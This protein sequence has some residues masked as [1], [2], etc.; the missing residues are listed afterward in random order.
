MARILVIDDEK[1]IRVTLS[2]ML[3]D[4]GHDVQ[5]VEDS[6]AALEQLARQNYDVVISDM[7]LP[8]LSGSALVERLREV[9]PGVP[10]I[11]M[12]G[13][14]SVDTAS[15]AVRAR[16][17]DYLLKPIRRDR[18]LA[19]V[20]AAADEK[21][22]REELERLRQE[23]RRYQDQLE[24]L[25]EQQSMNATEQRALLALIVLHAPLAVAVYDQD[26][27]YLFVSQ[28][29]LEDF[30]VSGSHLVGKHLYE[31]FPHIELARR[32]LHQRVLTGALHERAEDDYVR[33]DGLTIHSRW[34]FRPWT[35]GDG[36]IGGMITYSEGR[37][38]VG[39]VAGQG[40]SEVQKGE[41]NGRHTLPVTTHA[42]AVHELVLDEA[43]K[44]VDL[45]RH[46]EELHA[47]NEALERFTRA[48]T[49]RELRMIELKQEVNGLARLL[50]R[51]QPYP[52]D[53]LPA[54]QRSHDPGKRGSS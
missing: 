31:V 5:T 41:Q 44:P 29:Y 16:A 40:A 48:A 50:G 42:L 9:A 36:S 39:S 52:L 17:F 13:E 26:L 54:N 12:T 3:G 37:L 8:G 15:A 43:G 45:Q 7:I 49:N 20:Q 19:V 6:A 2:A 46:A 11:I 32:E 28:R 23:N 47:R 27:R 34:E 1:S 4:A 10:L 53:F 14:P 24:H 35:H 51:P 25:I 21:A 33:P 18:M 30:G 22:R 38:G